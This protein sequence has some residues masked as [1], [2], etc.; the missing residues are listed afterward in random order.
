MLLRGQFSIESINK[1]LLS[2]AAYNLSESGKNILDMTCTFGLS[3]KLDIGMFFIEL[4]KLGES[5]DFRGFA[6]SKIVLERCTKI[7][8]YQ[9]R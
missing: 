1:I 9:F 4:N 7:I 3:W 6:T 8:V 5:F 2:I